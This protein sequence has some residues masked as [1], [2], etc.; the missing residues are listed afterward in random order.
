MKRNELEKAFTPIP[1]DC[2]RAL[3]SAAHSVE[4][5]RVMKKKI[6]MALVFAMVAVLIAGVALAVMSLR[7]TG[8][9]IV[10]TEQTDGYYAQWPIDKKISLVNALTGLGYAEETDAVKQLVA[11]ALPP[12]EANRVAD[13][14]LVDF[15]GREVSEISFMEI[16]QAAWG[17]FE[18]WT[19]E[20]QA[21]Y[22][23]LMVDM[24]L[25]GQDHTLY[26]EPSGP[27]DEAE[28]IAIARREIA[29]GY[30]VPESA[31]DGYT[32]TTS[33]QVPEFAEPGDTQAWWYVE[34]M[35]PEGLPEAERPFGI[36]WVFIH[37]E[38]GALLESVESMLAEREAE[39][40]RVEAYLG[41]P[42]VQDINAFY[43]KYERANPR[44]MSLE[45]K[46]LYSEMFRHRVLEKVA[47]DP[48]FFSPAE[49]AAFVFAYGMPDAD[50][51]SQEEA[52]AIAE[53][54]LAEEMGYTER[55]IYF[56]VHDC[57]A[58][59]RFYYDV[60]DPE[61]PLWKFVFP[62]PG[63][64]WTSEAFQ[65]EVAVYYGES[66]YRRPAK[67]EIDAYTGEVKTAYVIDTAG[68]DVDT[69]KQEF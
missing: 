44:F 39:K 63:T 9:Q 32:V 7:D 43:A 14:V 12:E 66:P 16:M 62:V 28:A 50:A 53:G 45:D 18:K 4:E 38:T 8:R 21:W 1:E 60:T 19:R 68:F 55:E 31:L 23:Q 57:L 20:E 65:K 30:G 58:Y 41:D 67:V 24:G 17:P 6:P 29:K 11:G 13:E 54:V 37:P 56:V 47:Q 34:L 10:E 26:V 33:F 51:I 40:T 2:Y 46:A 3:M 36:F 49:Q 22:S 15:T 35:A 27:V 69:Y 64:Y 52:L 59:N 25:Q 48:D 5:D 61:T 42:L